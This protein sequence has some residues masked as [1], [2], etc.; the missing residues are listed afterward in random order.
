[1]GAS[2]CLNEMLIL[3]L[4]SLAIPG[5]AEN[6]PSVIMGEHISCYAFM[7]LIQPI[8][9]G[10]FLQRQGS[11]DDK[12]FEG[13]VHD[14]RSN[15]VGLR[16][17][18]SFQV[19]SATKYSVRFMFNRYPLR[20]Q[21]QALHRP[22]M[23]DRV[24]FPVAAHIKSIPANATRLTLHNPSIGSNH[25]QLLAVRTIVNLPVSS[26]PFVVYGPYV[27]LFLRRQISVLTVTSHLSDQAQARYG[28]TSC[29]HHK[30][31]Y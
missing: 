13:I 7:T 15:G 17:A 31:T 18:P 19:S 24:F 29:N 1:M 4:C 16:F 26:H 12:W 9:D 30:Y 22:F 5:L 3:V 6:R 20:R 10:V 27:S 14:V 11:P 23:E 25:N 2:L 21:H 8:G 28:N